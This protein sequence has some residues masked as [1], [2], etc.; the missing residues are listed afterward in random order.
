MRR[1]IAAVLLAAF[2]L[3]AAAIWWIVSLRPANTANTPTNFVVSRGDGVRETARKLKDANLIRDQVA[4][5][6][7]IKKLGIEKNIQAGTYTLSPNMTAIEIARKLT[8]GLDDLRLTI[9]E[10]WR[11][12]EVVDYLK[13]Q[14]ISGSEGVWDEE[15]KYF[16]ET[17]MVS[18][19]ATIDSVRALMRQTFNAKV[20]AITRE[21][22]IIASMVEREA[23][24]TIDRPLIA[25]VIHNRLEAGMALDIDATVQ[26][27]V[28]YTKNDGWWKKELT[29]E[30]LKIKS[31][32]NTYINPG[33]P[34]GPICNPGLSSIQAAVNPAKTDYLFYLAD[35]NGV[36]HYARTLDEHN[37]N[38]AK[39]LSQ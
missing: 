20:S 18:K 4:F 17:Y 21:Q 25:S 39:Y 14:N 5:F 28:G 38:V 9:P 27:A 3:A 33:L 31:P 19:S 23:K 11:S 16:P 6:L 1:I 15:G 12:E 37:A 32:Y 7:L 34:P 35:K 2:L 29:L 24:T 36:T 26:Y 22:L 30:D 13:K 10:G 8:V